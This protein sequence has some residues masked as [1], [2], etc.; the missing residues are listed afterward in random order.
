MVPVAYA[1]LSYT[2]N[3]FTWNNTS[4]A[5]SYTKSKVGLNLSTAQYLSCLL[6]YL[7]CWNV[8]KKHVKE[9]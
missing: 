4:T 2:W 9:T 7:I 8:K 5:D 3:K 6:V 1:Y